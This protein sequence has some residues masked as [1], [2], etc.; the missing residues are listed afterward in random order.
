MPGSALR[1]GI[2]EVEAVCSD[3]TDLSDAATVESQ[4]SASSTVPVQVFKEHD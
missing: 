2:T 4:L 3:A 1:A